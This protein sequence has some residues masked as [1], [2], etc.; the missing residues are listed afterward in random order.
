[1]TLKRAEA[2]EVSV[3]IQVYR[4]GELVTNDQGASDLNEFVR[5]IEVFESITSATLEARLVFQDNA[6]LLNAFTG[7][8]LFKISITGSVY[9]NT[10]YM[11]AYNIESRSRTNQ[12]SEVY[13]INLASDEYVKNE[14][15]NVFG[16]S[17]VI[18]KETTAKNIMETIV[19]SN[20]YLGSKKRVYVEESLNKHSFIIPNWRPFDCI[21]WLCNRAIRKKSPGKNLQGGYV[22]FEN[23][24]GYHFKSIDQLI[25]DVNGQSPDTKT[26]ANGTESAAKVRLYRYEYTPKRTSEDASTDQ[27]KIESINFPEERNFL[28]GL[29]HGT[30]SGFSIGLDPVTVSTS[31]MG[32]STDLSADAYRY[33]I[34]DSW[35][36]MSHLKGGK[37]VNPIA[38]MDAGIQS[39]IDYPKRVRY[40]IMPNQIF[41]PKSNTNP[42]RNYEQLVELQAYQWMRIE[43]IKNVK[44]QIVIPG[45]LDLYAGYGIDIDIPS[46]AKSGTT[47]KIDKR[48][49]GRYLIAGV[50][51]KIVNNNMATELL[52]LKD[53]VQ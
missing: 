28:M 7:S 10:Y 31:K 37:N 26:N 14:V 11:R 18:F 23:R 47:T 34:K 44:L 35:K 24:L 39:M 8:E 4:D 5:G 53:A 6:G 38:K 29:R 36:Q 33:S 16:N 25:D 41:D 17:E 46:T 1:M 12:T 27:F 19:R 51:H 13:I 48:Y 40:T 49:S 21:Y 15:V 9:D 32:V 50:S 52:L 3:R 43:S 22:F 20:Q 30:W 45:N 42:Q 2:G